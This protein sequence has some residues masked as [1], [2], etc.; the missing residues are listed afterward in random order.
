MIE[1][2]LPGLV[3]GEYLALGHVVYLGIPTQS[4]AWILMFDADSEILN[5]LTYDNV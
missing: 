3:L 2:P 4:Q 1:P 5:L